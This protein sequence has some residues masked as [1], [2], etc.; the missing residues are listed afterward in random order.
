MP[1]QKKRKTYFTAG[2]LIWL[3]SY[4]RYFIYIQMRSH[5]LH[6]SKGILWI[7]IILWQFWR[8]WS[9]AFVKVF[10]HWLKPHYRNDLGFCWSHFLSIYLVV[11]HLSTMIHVYLIINRLLSRGVDSRGTRTS[12]RAVKVMKISNYIIIFTLLILL[13]WWR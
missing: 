10:M 2:L 6:A 3:K 1:G 9:V 8:C 11:R 5:E 4:I 12:T 13:W 7:T